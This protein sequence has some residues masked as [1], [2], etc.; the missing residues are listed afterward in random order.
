MKGQRGLLSTMQVQ[1]MFTYNLI[2]ASEQAWKVGE[3]GCSLLGSKQKKLELR[4]V[5]RLSEIVHLV[6][7]R[8]QAQ[9]PVF[10]LS[11]QCFFH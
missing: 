6:Y 3:Q 2:S 10:R 1:R 9:A 11:T 8:G 7:S 4:D 5:I